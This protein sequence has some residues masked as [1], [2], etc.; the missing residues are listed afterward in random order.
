MRN[1]RYKCARVIF[2]ERHLKVLLCLLMLLASLFPLHIHAQQSDTTSIFRVPVQLDSFVVKS[3]FDVNAFIRRVRSDT[4]F[5]K[6]FKNM[7][8]VPYAADND[9]NVFDKN[10][11]VRAS[12]KSKTKQLINKGCRSTKVLEEQTTGDFYKRDSGYKYYTAALY[13]HLF[14]A[15]VP[16]CNETDI[17]AGSM[18]APESG[19]MAKSEYQLKQLIFNPGSKVS[20]VPLMGDRESIFDAGEAEKYD[21]KI[22]LELY[23]G[24]ECYVFRITPKKGYERKTLYDELTT[25]FRKSDFSIVARDYSL[26]YSTVVYDFNVRMKVRTAQIGGKLYP[27]YIN[28]DGNW[29]VITK[30]RERVRFTIKV[31]Y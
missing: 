27:T 25:W 7:R 1:T 3:S 15:K 24:Q 22:A 23:D 4:T 14:F 10:N 11:H 28:Y 17:V 29:H 18:D 19:E 9:I 31:S 8:L 30:K 6:A 26:S 16:V 2:P 12:L 20:G 5:Y 21:F 13:A